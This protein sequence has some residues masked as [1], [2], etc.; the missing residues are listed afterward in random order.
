M[1]IRVLPY[2]TPPN[3]ATGKLAA[4]LKGEG[5]KPSGVRT[6]LSAPQNSIYDTGM[7]RDS[8]N[9]CFIPSSVPYLPDQHVFLNLLVFL[10]IT[11]ITLGFEVCRD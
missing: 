1:L 11:S 7:V 8:V 9:L 6:A 4:K 10:T 2:F 5:R 3:V